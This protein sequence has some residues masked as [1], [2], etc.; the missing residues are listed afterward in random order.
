MCLNDMFVPLSHRSRQRN[1]FP[2]TQCYPLPRFDR[3]RNKLKLQLK[4]RNHNKNIPNLTIKL[5]T[6]VSLLND[7]KKK[8]VNWSS[9]QLT[10]EEIIRKKFGLSSDEHLLPGGRTQF[11]RSGVFSPVG[12]IEYSFMWNIGLLS[13]Q[14]KS[15]NYNNL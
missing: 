10:R 15:L 8:S 3:G 9:V 13:F 14:D 2:S 5:E 7:C 6:L 12:P 11:F 1:P 4:L